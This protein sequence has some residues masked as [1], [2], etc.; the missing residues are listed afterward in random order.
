MANFGFD[1]ASAAEVRD[2]FWCQA[3]PCAADQDAGRLNAVAAIAAVDDGQGGVLV[4]Q[5]LYLLQRLSQRMAVV[6][7]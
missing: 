7:V 6:R 4:G 5:D 2:Q 1:G 3:A